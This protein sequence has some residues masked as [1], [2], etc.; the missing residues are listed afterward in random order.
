MLKLNASFSKKV[1]VPGIEC[2]SHGYYATVEIELPDGLTSEQI[3]ARIHQTFALV[4]DSVEEEL[5]GEQ[6][7]PNAATSQPATQNQGRQT[8]GNGNGNGQDQ[9]KASPRQ[10]KF[11]TDLGVQHRIDL[12]GLNALTMQVFKVPAVG[13][14][15][16]KQASSFIDNFDEIAKTQGRLAA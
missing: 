8:N 4:R 14:L 7:A 12:K 11:L 6:S 9:R 13:D 3:Q 15:S 1:P 16:R 10:I 5:R 2:S